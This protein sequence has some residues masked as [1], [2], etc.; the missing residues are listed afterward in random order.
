MQGLHKTIV[1]SVHCQESGGKA[2][3]NRKQLNMV[4]SGGQN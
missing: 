3:K 2:L 1:V 4:V